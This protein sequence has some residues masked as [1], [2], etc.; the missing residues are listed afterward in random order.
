MFTFVQLGNH[1]QTLIKNGHLKFGIAFDC[2]N[3]YDD[4]RK[5]NDSS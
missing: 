3:H 2:V 4:K 1:I 5:I